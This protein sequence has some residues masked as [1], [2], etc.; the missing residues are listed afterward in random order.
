MENQ[1][2]T[3]A[4]GN[5]GKETTLRCGRCRSSWYC[6]SDCQKAH[7]SVHQTTCNLD[8]TIHRAGQLLQEVVFVFSELCYP[9]KVVKIQDEGNELWIYDAPNSP[10]RFYKFPNH[11]VANEKDKKM[12][13]TTLWCTEAHAY[14]HDFVNE[15]LKGKSISHSTP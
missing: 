12:I 11:L 13:L 1:N 15:M 2:P 9:Y 6:S 3:N 7:Y 10:G 5:C 4:C 8:Q 14:L